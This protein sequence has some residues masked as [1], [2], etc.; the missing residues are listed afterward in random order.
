MKNRRTYALLVGAAGL[1]YVAWRA[2]QSY[3]ELSEPSPQGERDVLRYA[4]E[5]RRLAVLGTLRSLTQAW[6]LPESPVAE[7]FDAL[8]ARAPAWLAPAAF[9]APITAVS[10]LL[11]L[12]VDFIEGYVTERRYGLTEQRPQAW[13]GEQIKGVAL[14]TALSA[15][16]AT[17]GGAV[18]R[19]VP[20]GWPL[21]G[22]AISLP[23]LALGNIVVP[24]YVM[25][26]FNRF[27]P[28][29]GEIEQRLR[30]LA[31]RYGCGNAE[32]LKMNMSAQTTKANAFVIG[33]G[34]THRIVIGDTLLDNFTPEEIE[35]V[36]AHELGHYVAHDT[37]RLMAAAEALV[38][39]SLLFAATLPENR[40]T[41]MRERP[42][43][44]AQISARV[45]LASTLLRP[46][47][48]KLTRDRERAA[49]RF[50]VAATGAPAWGVAAFERL[51]EQNLAETESPR[52]YEILFAS[53]PSLRER[54][55][56]LRGAAEER[57]RS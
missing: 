20:R 6:A 7:V 57:A 5:R 11:E 18:I 1:S 45:A 23:L 52:W 48:L 10:A 53:H 8:A 9:A 33:I 4:Q 51:A 19:R 34:S 36:V 16:L 35:F 38:T 50:A 40:D 26:L 43:F 29:D 25:P 54:I 47:V 39:A 28:I 42:R 15:I 22:A 21:V 41:A 12:P 24:L 37:Y 55:A 2:W 56:A 49:D 30:A 27:E 13:L 46:L 44:L 3:M 14:A 32:I 31:E 17:I